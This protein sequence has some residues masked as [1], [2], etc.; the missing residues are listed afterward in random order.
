MGRPAAPGVVRGSWV[1]IEQSVVPAGS[2]ITPG[3]AHGE[4]AHLRDAAEAA[5]AE[6][7]TIAQRVQADGHADEAAIFLAQ[8]SIARDPTLVAAATERINGAAED[9]VSA[10]QA[11]AESFAE[12][13]RSLDDELLAA[14][15]V[16]ILDVNDPNQRQVYHGF[17][18]NFQY[19]FAGQGRLIGGFTPPPGY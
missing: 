9:A 18:V 16:D 2:R 5:A 11:A 15:A 1:R 12:Q 10:I 4:I 17:D 8:A 7:E 6:L 13:M 19:R 14:R 3:A